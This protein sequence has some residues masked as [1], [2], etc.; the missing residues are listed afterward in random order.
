[1][2]IE[3]IL[4]AAIIIIPQWQINELNLKYHDIES[5]IEKHE[6][7]VSA[8]EYDNNLQ[9][10]EPE[11]WFY[12]DNCKSTITGLN[13]KEIETKYNLKFDSGSCPVCGKSVL[14]TKI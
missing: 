5:K 4:T 2:L 7:R 11:I 3:A 8:L 1:M 10:T 9:I 13:V 12:C 6:Y 14:K